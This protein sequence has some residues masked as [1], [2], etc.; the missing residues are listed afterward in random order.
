MQNHKII[1]IIKAETLIPAGAYCYTPVEAPCAENGWVFK[2]KLCPFWEFRQDIAEIQGKQSAG[3]CSYLRA[4]DWEEGGTF[5]LWDQCKECNVNF[6]DE[7][8][9]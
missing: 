4:G 3:Y 6:E 2:T 5:L 1:P 9:S 8:A 7:D